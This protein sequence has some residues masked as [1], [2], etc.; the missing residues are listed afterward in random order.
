MKNFSAL[1]PFDS[2][3]LVVVP[4]EP[5]VYLIYD[6]DGPVYG[7]RTKDL[8]RRLREHLLQF[9]SAKVA[10][11]IRAGIPLRFSFLMMDTAEI[12][13]AEGTLIAQLGLTDFANIVH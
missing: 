5:G 13:E 1:R 10:E 7:G 2:A 12:H 11:L 8:S 6:R 4:R 9:G 3:S